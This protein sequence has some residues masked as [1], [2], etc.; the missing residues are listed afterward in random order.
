MLDR[1]L[2]DDVVLT[3]LLPR[4]SVVVRMPE[5]AAA[6]GRILDRIPVGHEVLLLEDGAVAAMREAVAAATGDI[7]V[8]LDAAGRESPEE[9][10][11][12]ITALCDGADVATGT[13]V[14]ARGRPTL[15]SAAATLLF[16]ARRTDITYRRHAFWRADAD[17]IIDVDDPLLVPFRAARS[18]LRVTEVPCRPGERAPLPPREAARILALLLRE[19]LRPRRHGHVEPSPAR[20]RRREP[21]LRLVDDAA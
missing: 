15:V 13:R 12:F 18:G 1:A 4:V 16:G 20:P 14:A 10:A 3:R 9:I 5:D 11:R 8:T 17:R 21:V 19:R 6:L 7:V 2:P